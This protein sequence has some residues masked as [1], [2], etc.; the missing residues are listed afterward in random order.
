M[1]SGTENTTIKVV[2]VVMESDGHRVVVMIAARF[3]NT[4]WNL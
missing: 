3:A 4:A 1:V 2:V